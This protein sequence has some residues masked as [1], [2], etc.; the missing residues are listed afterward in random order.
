MQLGEECVQANRD[1]NA[2]YV[3]TMAVVQDLVHFTTLQAA[4]RNEPNPEEAPVNYYGISYG[5]T[6]G[7]TLAATYPQRIGRMI[8][9]GNQNSEDWYKGA[10]LH[11]VEDVDLIYDGFFTLC[12]AAGPENC[13][14]YATDVKKRFDELLA[15]MANNPINSSFA[16]ESCRFANVSY[17]ANAVLAAAFDIMYKPVPG[18]QALADGLA[19]LEEDDLADFCDEVDP[20]QVT[21]IEDR[22]KYVLISAADAA[23]HSLVDNL[24]SFHE[25]FDLVNL[26]SIYAGRKYALESPLVG[27]AVRI[28]PPKSQIFPG[29]STHAASRPY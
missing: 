4:Q 22:E 25:V 20:F 16:G 5:T 26:T 21:T 8:L 15:K 10:D 2:K 14:F 1:T 6:I 18:F 9:D 7:H 27:A 19:A 11:A 28:M 29:E 17:N 23:G 3:G 12:Q 13:S 24:D